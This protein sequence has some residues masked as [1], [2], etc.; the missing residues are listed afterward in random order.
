MPINNHSASE[1]SYLAWREGDQKVLGENLSDVT[2]SEADSLR[3]GHAASQRAA[4]RRVQGAH[5]KAGVP[6]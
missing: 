1:S 4:P 5:A 3:D 6:S 2:S